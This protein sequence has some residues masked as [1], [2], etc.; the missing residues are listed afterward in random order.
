[1][2]WTTDEFLKRL[3]EETKNERLKLRSGKKHTGVDRQ[4]LCGRLRK[5]LGSFPRTVTPLQPIV[6]EKEDY[7]DYYLE[8]IKYTTMESVDVPVM[9]LVPKDGKGSWPAVLACHGHGNGQ[10]DAVGLALN[11]SVLGEPGIHNRFAVELVKRGLLVVIPEIMGFGVRRMAEEII[12]NPNYS[13]CGTLSSQLLMFG[14]TL[15]GMRVYEAIRALDYIQS[16]DDVIASRIGIF[17]F[18]GGSLISAFTAGLDDRIKATVLAG[19]T[20]TFQGSILAMHH[21][22]DNYL[23]GILLDAEQPELIGLI[24]PR[25]LFVESGENDPIFPVKN[26]REAIAELKEIY[27]GMNVL[28]CFQSD[29]FPGSHEIS[30]RKS[31]DWLAECLRS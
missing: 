31:F 12:A 5:A 9:V 7:G 22:I 10:R 15:A 26:V 24:A 8:H 27:N 11:G 2:N 13:S 23:P 28:D 1:M 25:N 19:W 4:E 17:G 3:Y 21:C 29:L 30:G 16:R 14:R 18:S 6:L 20:S